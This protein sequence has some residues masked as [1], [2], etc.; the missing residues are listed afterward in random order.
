MAH[1]QADSNKA[2]TRDDIASGVPNST[3]FSR[4]TLL[5]VSSEGR[6]GNNGC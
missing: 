3:R 6:N 4:L 2:V 1:R 5:L